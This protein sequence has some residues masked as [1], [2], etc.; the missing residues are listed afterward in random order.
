MTMRLV[1][2]SLPFSIH[3]KQLH[4]SSL[5]SC[6]KIPSL[7]T[8]AFHLSVPSLIFS[9]IENSLHFIHSPM[10]QTHAY[11]Y[12]FSGSNENLFTI[13]LYVKLNSSRSTICLEEY[14]GLLC[15]GKYFLSLETIRLDCILIKESIPILIIKIQLVMVSIYIPLIPYK[16]NQ[17]GQED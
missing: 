11:Y 16:F 8:Q 12:G 9:S 1:L 15:E 5:H 7:R 17:E 6:Q 13:P 14:F 2:Q 10:H 3:F 4:I